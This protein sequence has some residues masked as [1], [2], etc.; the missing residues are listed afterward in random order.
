MVLNS[1]G[2]Y[3]VFQ[4][5]AHQVEQIHEILRPDGKGLFA[6][7]L[8]VN[9]QP[10]RHGKSTLFMMIVLWLFM[11]RDNFTIQ[12]LGNEEGHSRRT[13]YNRLKKTIQNTPKLREKIPDSDITNQEI[14]RFKHG[15][16]TSVIQAMTGLSLKSSFGDRQTYYGFLIITPALIFQFLTHGRRR[17]WT[18]KIP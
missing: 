18:A 16:V 3:E 17:S 6:I 9:V 10:R 5:T 14:R 15:K 13:Q 12:L 2:K 11:T 1:K 7:D 8:A 4:P